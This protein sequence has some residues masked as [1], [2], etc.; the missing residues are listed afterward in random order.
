MCVRVTTIVRYHS[1]CC[2]Y[3]DCE[4]F[5]SP[6]FVRA[7]QHR[8]LSSV[9]DVSGAGVLNK[10]TKKYVASKKGSVVLTLEEIVRPSGFR[11]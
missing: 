10:Q 9:G 1:Y 11:C 6:R 3:V 7:T 5:R 8:Q 2:T 4:W